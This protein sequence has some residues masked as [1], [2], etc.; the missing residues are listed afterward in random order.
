[1]SVTIVCQSMEKVDLRIIMTFKLDHV[2][3]YLNLTMG[4]PVCVLCPCHEPH[5]FW[6]YI[7]IS[8]LQKWSLVLILTLVALMR[9]VYMDG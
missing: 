9:E 2:T 6:S 7:P 1:M 5:H 3:H 4:P 8:Q